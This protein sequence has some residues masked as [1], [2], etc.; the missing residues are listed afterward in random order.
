MRHTST[1]YSVLWPT[2]QNTFLVEPPNFTPSGNLSIPI[3][4]VWASKDIIVKGERE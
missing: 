2:E 3:R 1:V 4:C